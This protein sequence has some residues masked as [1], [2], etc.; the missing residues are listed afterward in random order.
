MWGLKGVLRR[1]S[2]AVKGRKSLAAIPVAGKKTVSPRA[3][4]AF[5]Q[6]QVLLGRGCWQGETESETL[7]CQPEP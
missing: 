1:P 4:L 6:P 7:S 5:F 2:S 3:L